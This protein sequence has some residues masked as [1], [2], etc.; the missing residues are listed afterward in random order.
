MRKEKLECCD[1]STLV[2]FLMIYFSLRYQSPYVNFQNSSQE[3][4]QN[5]RKYNDKVA[6]IMFGRILFLFLEI[7]RLQDAV[8]S[9]VCSMS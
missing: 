1:N 8:L 9:C 4:I 5:S 7:L 6:V 2:C 3:E